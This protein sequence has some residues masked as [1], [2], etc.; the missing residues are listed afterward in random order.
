M[1]ELNQEQLERQNKVD[2]AIMVHLKAMAFELSPRPLPENWQPVWDI[3]IIGDIRSSMEGFIAK[4]L[5]IKIN[6]DDYDKFEMEF[7]PFIEWDKKDEPDEGDEGSDT[8][9]GRPFGF[10]EPKLERHTDESGCVYYTDDG[11]Y[12]TTIHNEYVTEHLKIYNGWVAPFR[13]YDE[14]D[15][16]LEDG[17]QT[18]TEAMLWAD[19]CEDRLKQDVQIVNMYGNTVT[20][21]LE[22]ESRTECETMKPEF[23]K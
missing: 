7:Y 4:A 13:I 10:Y 8:E 1:K 11:G 20:A 16:R 23:P 12:D 15:E 14:D 3:D 21:M 2:N 9:E 18:P 17:L 6:S 22:S 19:R 5:G